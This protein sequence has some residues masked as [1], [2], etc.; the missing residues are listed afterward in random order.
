MLLNYDDG[1]L[2]TTQENNNNDNANNITLLFLFA[3][4]PER[5]TKKKEIFHFILS[6]S[7]GNV[8]K[9]DY[10]NEFLH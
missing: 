5:K 8:G 6:E 3:F 2:Y 10:F 4:K 7:M 9:W 1:I